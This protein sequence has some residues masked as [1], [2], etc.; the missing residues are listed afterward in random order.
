[1][2]DVYNGCTSISVAS[3]IEPIG[4]NNSLQR[5]KTC[6]HDEFKYVDT[7]VSVR[8]KRCPNAAG[9]FQSIYQSISF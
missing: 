4:G 7:F 6:R 8:C 3:D 2:S 5:V 1:M 9:A